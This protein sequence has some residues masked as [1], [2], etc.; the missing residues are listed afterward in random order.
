MTDTGLGLY[1]EREMKNRRYQRR[2]YESYICIDN[3]GVEKTRL[4]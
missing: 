1:K 2:N 4:E 3:K